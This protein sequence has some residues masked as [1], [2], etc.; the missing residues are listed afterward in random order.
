MIA[1]RL[2]APVRAVHAAAVPVERG[3]LERFRR[4]AQPERPGDGG[5]TL[6]ARVRPDRGLRDE[7]RRAFRAGRPAGRIAAVRVV[8]GGR[9]ECGRRFGTIKADLMD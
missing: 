7:R 8:D 4:Q 1:V 6:R 2:D 9:L 5:R 3:Q